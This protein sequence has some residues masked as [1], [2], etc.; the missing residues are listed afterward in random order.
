MDFD[1]QHD[2]NEVHSVKLSTRQRLFYFDLKRSSNGLFIK[3]SEKSA[4][5]RSTIMFD[6]ED[7]DDVIKTLQEIK[8]KAYEDQN[9]EDFGG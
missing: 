7:L 5:G 9:G 1:N 6:S 3:I 8:K 2:N 4:K